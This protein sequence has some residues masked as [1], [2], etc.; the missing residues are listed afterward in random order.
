MLEVH[1]TAGW[2]ILHDR[3]IGTPKDAPKSL[4]VSTIS[5][6]R[7]RRTIVIVDPKFHATLVRPGGFF[8]VVVT[9]RMSGSEAL[10]TLHLFQQAVLERRVAP[11]E[12]DVVLFFG[13]TTVGAHLVEMKVVGT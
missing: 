8:R 9:G 13:L 12:H 5:G 4:D 10:S 3:V 2:L 7:G 11:A 6:S 1:D